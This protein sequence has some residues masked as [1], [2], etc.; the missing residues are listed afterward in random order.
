MDSIEKWREFN[1]LNSI[2]E[3]SSGLLFSEKNASLRAL[4]L[5]IILNY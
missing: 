3:L 2:S 5:G 4:A 1:W